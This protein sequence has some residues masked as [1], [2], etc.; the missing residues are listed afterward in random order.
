MAT[1]IT[2]Q[3]SPHFAI[4][5]ILLAIVIGSLRVA[6]VKSELFQAIAHLYVGGLLGCYAGTSH[7]FWLYLAWIL[8]LLE[9]VCFLV[10]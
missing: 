10:L 4:T 2:S 7:E 5:N 6:G 9:L 1:E 8:S 3:V